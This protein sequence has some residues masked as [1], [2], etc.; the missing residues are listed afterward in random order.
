MQIEIGGKQ[1]EMLTLDDVQKQLDK[2]RIA[3]IRHDNAYDDEMPMTYQEMNREL[4]WAQNI[5]NDLF[6]Y[7]KELEK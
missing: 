7:Y 3:V 6:E 5:I 1:V 4:L 2:A